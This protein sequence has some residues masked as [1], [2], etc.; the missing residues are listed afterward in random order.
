[1]NTSSLKILQSVFFLDLS[2][3]YILARLETHSSLPFMK[4]TSLQLKCITLLGSN[5]DVVSFM[6]ILTRGNK[7]KTQMQ[8]L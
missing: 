4:N 3:K 5:L 7:A 6:I 1:M 8:T 2:L